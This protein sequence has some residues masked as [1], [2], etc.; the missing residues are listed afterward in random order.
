MTTRCFCK[1]GLM[2]QCTVSRPEQIACR[3]YEKSMVAD[4]CMNVDENLS[5]HCWS[6]KAQAY[7][8]YPHGREDYM[9]EE[10]LLEEVELR[11]PPQAVRAERTCIDC[12]LYTCSH[13]IQENQQAQPRGGL[14]HDDL[15]NIARGC[16]DYCDAET[17][18]STINQSLRGIKP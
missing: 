5:N 3:F 10:L 2:S 11:E 4:R 15:I 18:N 17:L 13:V 7:G 8:Y 9:E 1:K 16:K 12:I 6:P 14:T